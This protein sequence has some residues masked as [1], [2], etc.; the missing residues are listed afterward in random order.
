[1]AQAESAFIPRALSRAKAKGMWQFIPSRGK[2]YGLRQTWWID[3][4]SDPEKSTRA[5]ARH[6]KDL[7]EE[8]GDWYLAMAAYNAGPARITRAMQKTGADSFWE[9]AD[10]KALPKETINY[11][12]NILAL[13]II[14]K[15]PEKYGFEVE[16]DS[17]LEVER[18]T[19]EKATDLRVIAEAIDVPIEDLRNLN[20]D[21]LR[22]T[23]PPEDSEFELILPKG[24][25]EKFMAEVASLPDNKRVLFRY[26]T[27]KKGDTLSV[28]A[29]KYG[30]SVAELTQA[31][32][33][34]KKVTLRVGQEL[35]IPMS[36]VAPPTPPKASAS[37]LAKTK[38][39][40][41]SYTVAAGD[42]LSKIASKFHVSVKQL[43]VWN[44]L[45]ST[46]L[47]AGKRLI[48][49]Q[50]AVMAQ[51]PKADAASKIVHEVQRGETLNQI[52]STYNTTVD[53]IVASNK[54]N[55][56]KVLHPGD[57]I[58]IFPGN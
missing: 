32:K 20:S 40:I 29:R 43:Q 10:K 2:E 27:V 12:P 18:V 23:T 52:A 54:A 1:V 6:L 5:A 14:G 17:P 41:T 19:V 30:T 36:G 7:Y 39:K 26:H 34:P 42:T 21:V 38:A 35:M 22:W 51:T 8:F 16:P 9:L 44:S 58:T 4:R 11:V 15:N 48:V 28:V 56:L 50:T 24:H 3:E 31:N 25:T 45:K 13:A 33:L 46:R 57:Q 55:S 53:A 37:T 47:V 49:G